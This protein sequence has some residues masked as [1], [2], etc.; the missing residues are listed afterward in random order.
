MFRD[1]VDDDHWKT[2]GTIL[3]D[4]SNIYVPTFA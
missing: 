2:D 3:V 4:F 1:L